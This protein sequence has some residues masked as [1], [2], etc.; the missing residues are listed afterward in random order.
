MTDSKACMNKSFLCLDKEWAPHAPF[1]S[2]T[3]ITVCVFYFILISHT[4]THTFVC[5]AHLLREHG[6]SRGRK[7]SERKA[8]GEAAGEMRG[9][10]QDE[11]VR[12]RDGLRT[13]DG[14]ETWHFTKP[15]WKTCMTCFSRSRSCCSRLWSIRPS[16][17][18]I[19]ARVIVVFLLPL[20]RP[21]KWNLPSKFTVGWV[22]LRCNSEAMM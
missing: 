4:H 15:L 20:S 11:R 2:D 22:T 18:F 3:W 13:R 6:L 14:G 16:K 12:E 7:H 21:Q 17:Y 1:C 5:T 19:T 9:D 8:A 10:G